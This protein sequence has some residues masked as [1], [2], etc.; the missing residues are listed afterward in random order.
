MWD[1]NKAC[2]TWD[3]YYNLYQP[4]T[5]VGRKEIRFRQV[6]LQF[7][8]TW[9]K[10][11]DLTEIEWMVHV[12]E[13]Y[14]LQSISSKYIRH[15]VLQCFPMHFTIY[16]KLLHSVMFMFKVGRGQDNFISSFSSVQGQGWHAHKTGYKWSLYISVN[17]QAT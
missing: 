1:T 5:K 14:L 2:L 17:T 15:S 10:T 13:E 7:F 3:Y 8:C 9:I 12:T 11:R 6:S 4:N 16:Q